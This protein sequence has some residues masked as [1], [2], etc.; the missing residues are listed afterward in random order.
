[1]KLLLFNPSFNRSISTDHHDRTVYNTK[2]I[3]PATNAITTTETMASSTTT[4]T[5][6]SGES[7][8][9]T[10]PPQPTLTYTAKQ[11][12]QWIKAYYI[13]VDIPFHRQFYLQR[14]LDDGGEELTLVNRANRF[15]HLTGYDALAGSLQ[16]YNEKLFPSLDGTG[17][18]GTTPHDLFTAYE[19]QSSTESKE[20][21]EQTR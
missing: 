4:T 18:D 14:L 19:Q 7:K 21:Q 10:P 13:D 15:A 3:L 9:S 11:R 17:D 1:M 8:T 12:Q 20:T 6:T 2:Y 16:E 5:T